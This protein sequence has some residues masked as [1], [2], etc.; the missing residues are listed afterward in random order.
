ML[1]NQYFIPKIYENIIS[2]PY[3]AICVWAWKTIEIK[4]IDT[5]VDSLAHFINK[6]GVKVR[7]IQTGNLSSSLRLMAVGLIFGLIFALVLSVL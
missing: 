2:K 5:T 1:I 4:L 7:P 3:Y 6:L